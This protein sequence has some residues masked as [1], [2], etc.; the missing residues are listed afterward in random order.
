MKKRLVCLFL[1]LVMLLSVVLT[2]C[3]KKDEEEAKENIT[4]GA[5]ETAITLTMWVVS[6]EKVSDA[7]AA[8]VTEKLNAITKPKFKTELVLTYL[9]EDEYE[10][11]LAE[12]ITAYEEAKKQAESVETEAPEET[13]TGEAVT[14]TDETETNEYGQSV[15]KYPDL[16]ANQVDIIYIAGED[17]YVDF[18]EKGW[19]A[20]LDTELASS[21]KKIKE[22]VSATLLSAAKYNGVTYAIPN[23][24]V[25]GEYTYMLLN[26]ELMQTYAQDAYANLDM[27]DGFYNEYLY[28][29]LNLVRRFESDNVIPI[30]ASYEDCLKLLA[31]YWYVDAADYTMLDKFSLFGY[32]YDNMADLTRGSTILGYNNL[33]EDEDFIA[34]YLQLNRFR[35]DDY[36]RKEDDTRTEAAIKFVRGSYADA[37]QYEDDYYSVIVEYPTAS[38]EDIYG[39]MFG[40]CT[41][42]R[43]V[44]RSMEIITYL[45]TNAAFRN[46]LQYGVEDMHYKTVEDENG[47]VTGVERLNNDY[48]MDLYATGNM[49]I[50]YPDTAA[51]MTNEV[52]ESGK[53]QNRSSLVDPL[54]GFDFAGF[55]ATTTPEA[56]KEEISDVGYNLK[57]STGY[58]KD[59]MMQNK[60]IAAWINEC[61]A[62]G[63]GVYVLETNLVEGQNRT[64]NY[65]IYNNMGKTTFSIE[66]I[67]DV[68]TSVD[69]KTGK[70]IETQT[71]LDF[72]LTYGPTSGAGYEL[73]MMSLYTKKTNSYEILCKIDGADT[74]VSVKTMDELLTVDLMNT[75][76]YTIEAY[77][78]V[79]RATFVKN[80]V[81][82]DWINKIDLHHADKSNT[83]RNKITNYLMTYE[84]TNEEGKKEY[85]YVF[86]RCMQRF[87]TALRVQPTGDSGKLNLTIALTEDEE[88]L[89]D[90]AVSRYSLCYIRVTVNDNNIVPTLSLTVNG[91]AQKIPTENVT[92]STVDPDFTM[93]GNLDT[94]L[95]KFMQTLNDDL[96]G[97]L[98]TKYEE[99][100]LEYKAA[101]EQ[102]NSASAEDAVARR[103]ALDA[104]MEKFEVLIREIGYLITTEAAAPVYNSANFPNLYDTDLIKK[105]IVDD[106]TTPNEDE[107]MFQLLTL[108]HRYVLNAVSET[109]IKITILQLPDNKLLDAY[110]GG[111]EATGESYVYF[112]SIYGI[113]YAW[114]QKYGYLPK[115]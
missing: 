44:S 111:D 20:E 30:D 56:E 65:Y 89:T 10:A 112:D 40:V 102:Y 70:T 79:T 13:E 66:E 26:K 32:H 58:S 6:E 33:F 115:E 23:N 47:V 16:V 72:V 87:E 78:S 100:A 25:I 81:L 3:S 91:E 43:N 75:N 76:E 106:N 51:G 67:R 41:Y 5:S 55:S 104:A 101:I 90:S 105:Y 42:A 49:F 84:T 19:L 36:F 103:A 57:Y 46:L 109:P 38:S 52:W 93:I 12:T 15:I 63:S 95:V 53:V 68:E 113:Y 69:E 24:R 59:V 31:H 11:K 92:A 18:I 28:S 4:D 1:C 114:M 110:Y 77:D 35:M 64:V 39:N 86:Y 96:I 60:V 71:N 21:S 107:K 22:Y 37:A 54:L 14:V 34:D 9:T 27:I 73:S 99:Y 94:E 82:Y 2:S 98:E 88:Y 85:T 74:A 8:A 29:F 108:L 62:T 48:V 61:D 83:Q 80:N 45:N 17:M 7:A 97:F 50:A